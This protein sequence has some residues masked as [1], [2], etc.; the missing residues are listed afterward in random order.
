[1]ILQDYH[2]VTGLGEE[3]NQTAV[4]ATFLLVV[5]FNQEMYKGTLDRMKE[6][7]DV[8]KQE[9]DHEMAEVINPQTESK[10]N[11]TGDTY[12]ILTEGLVDLDL[13]LN[14]QSYEKFD[15]EDIFI[16]EFIPLAEKVV[17][18]WK[19]HLSTKAI[20]PVFL[21]HF[22]KG[23]AQSIKLEIKDKKHGI[24]LLGALY[25]EKIVRKVK[26]FL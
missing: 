19:T 12:L 24:S 6:V 3:E 14:N 8:F 18:Q 16:S 4:D 21:K 9:L 22:E 23:L 5:G 25:F 1:M 11:K 7:H 15:R 17:R 10:T 13:D 20:L 26:S 2:T